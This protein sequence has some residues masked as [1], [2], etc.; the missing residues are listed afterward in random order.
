MFKIEWINHAGFILNDTNNISLACDP[1][2]K[3]NVFNKGW[4]LLANSK[5]KVEDLEKVNFIWASHEH[6]DHFDVSL[7]KNIKDEKRG[8]ISFLYQKTNDKKVL[9]FIKNLG[10]KTY[11]LEIGEK[12]K[13]SKDFYITIVG[14]YP[15]SDSA[16][17]IELNGKKI[18]NLND[19]SIRL[20]QDI[21]SLT[22]YLGNK[23]DMLMTQYSYANWQGNLNYQ[24]KMKETADRL[25][26][27]SVDLVNIFK[28][29]Y[30]FPF[31][32]HIYFSHEENF[33]Q[34]KYS[35]K[36][37]DM[38]DLIKSKTNSYPIVL[39][40]GETWNYGEEINIDNNI[41]FYDKKR[42]LIKPMHMSN[43]ESIYDFSALKEQSLNFIKKIKENHRTEREVLAY[44]KF[45]N[46]KKRNTTFYLTDLKKSFNF[47]YFEG[48]KEI[49]FKRQQVD[50]ITSSSNM[51]YLFKNLWGT[52][53]LSINARFDINTLDGKKK[54]FSTF[55][56][57]TKVSNQI[58]DRIK[59]KDY[60]ANKVKKFFKK[61]K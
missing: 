18:L 30:Y 60:I 7:Y 28:P 3:G 8:K 13:I 40:P 12:Y 33:F 16:S 49:S 52:D 46:W 48:L 45:I 24:S 54:F 57:A 50:L 20:D 11:E 37:K 43:Q 9:N 31:A 21:Q 61:S 19:C 23:V 41:L 10:F 17:L 4:D 51:H 32:S 34:N 47:D 5:H 2:I 42:S 27:K 38:Y 29:K 25:L 36:M 59:L 26:N 53:T 1:W 39:K 44:Q 58:I 15:H 6:P 22:K 56:I 55:S 14:K 35:N